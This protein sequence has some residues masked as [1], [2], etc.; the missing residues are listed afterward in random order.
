MT[1]G[2]IAPATLSRIDTPP[3]LPD[4]SN[5]ESSVPPSLFLPEKFPSMLVACRGR[6]RGNC[7]VGGGGAG[8][9]S[10]TYEYRCNSNESLEF[11]LPYEQLS[12]SSR[13][14][15]R[16]GVIPRIEG[17]LDRS[18]LASA[19]QHC[20]VCKIAL[21]E[22]GGSAVKRFRVKEMLLETRFRCTQRETVANETRN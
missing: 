9:C 1:L 5:V 8:W 13:R 12:F 18:T 19:K 11:D 4:K 2:W 3:Y 17:A 20:T 22:A 10:R 7:G 14:I 6:T 16:G 21:R 15:H